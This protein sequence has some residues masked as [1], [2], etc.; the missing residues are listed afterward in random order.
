M[1]AIFATALWSIS[2]VV[3][4]AE[5]WV[6]TF[7]SYPD[8]Q[9]IL[10]VDGWKGFEGLKGDAKPAPTVA[11]GIG[12]DGTKA[13]SIGIAE[14][15]R[16]DNY[17]LRFTLPEA[18]E[19]GAVWIQCRIKQPAE[20]KSGLFLDARGPER[21]QILARVAAGPFENETVG[22]KLRWHS[23]FSRPY[24]RLYSLAELDSS[25]WQTLTMRLDFDTRSFAAWV[26]D[27]LLGEEMPFSA[28]A[29]FSQLHFA[30]A[31]SPESPALIDNLTIGRDAPEGMEAPQLLPEPED[32][33]IFRFAAIGDPQLGFAGYDTDKARFQTAVDQVNRSGADLTLILGDMVH[34]DDNEEA[35]QDC[36]EIANGLDGPHYYVRGNHEILE[37]YQKYFHERSDFSV[38]H[39]GVR[40]VVI[41]AIGNHTGLTE[42]QLAFVEKEFTAATEAEEDIVLSIHVSPWQNNDKGRGKYNQIG[43]GRERLRELMKEH[44]VALCL[45]GHYHTAVWGTKEDET[46]YLVLPGTAL[47]KAGPV[48]WC[49]FDVYP[50]RIVMHQKPLFFAYETEEVTHINGGNGWASYEERK[51]RYPYTQQGPLTI[52]RRAARDR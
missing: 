25:T 13:L 3:C 52:G 38:I 43:E 16:G 26:D 32:D 51:A 20:W 15:F 18:Y 39:K 36:A 8:N 6:E 50:D 2:C 45:S 11:A 4:H 21:G 9:L 37:L 5:N 10:E 48:G 46:Q 35:Y 41:D 19:D 23:A 12:V 34:A 14:P 42:E 7:D 33:H 27:L 47:A 22:K 1:K 40:F 49:V 31:G 24:W 28:D 29:P 44:Q 30:F 17:G